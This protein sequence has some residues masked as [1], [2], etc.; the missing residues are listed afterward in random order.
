MRMAQD[1]K[2]QEV[3][4]SCL[5]TRR[6]NLASHCE[7]SNDLGD[8]DIEQVRRMERFGPVEETRLDGLPSRSAQKD[9]EQSRGVD[10]NHRLSRSARTASAVFTESLTADRR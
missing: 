8:L 3:V 1:G 4:E 7:P 2:V 9:L 10:D 6:V 5:R